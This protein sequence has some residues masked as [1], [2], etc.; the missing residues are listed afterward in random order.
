MTIKKKYKIKAK[1]ENPELIKRKHL[2]IVNAAKDLFCK[3]G[4]HQTTMRDISSASQIELSYMYRYISGKNDILYLFYKHLSGK[5]KKYFEELGNSPDGD[6]IEQLRKFIWSFLN[7]ANKYNR[8]ILTM[9]TESR[10]LESNWLQ[11][12]L[13]AESENTKLIE[14][15]LKAGVSKGIF[16]IEDTFMT[17]NIIQY[18]LVIKAMRGWNF[19][20]RYG[21]EKFVE[22]I[23]NYILNSLCV[24]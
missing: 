23:T 4:Y 7:L 8:E 15:F 14:K 9:Y 13:E 22:I 20:D 17:A 18:L 3:K 2:Q 24:S 10:H 21:F 16:K 5:W 11:M 12:I 19:K 6:T 1:V